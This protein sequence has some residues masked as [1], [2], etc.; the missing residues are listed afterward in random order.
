MLHFNV[1]HMH[2]PYFIGNSA[3]VITKRINR[4]IEWIKCTLDGKRFTIISTNRTVLKESRRNLH[5][6]HSN[7]RSSNT[8]RPVTGVQLKVASSLLY[9]KNPQMWHFKKDF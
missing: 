5:S 8:K 4:R 6:K 1:D 9:N 2:E 3:S 7:N